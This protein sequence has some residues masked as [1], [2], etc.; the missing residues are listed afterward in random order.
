MTQP[1][2]DSP[3]ARSNEPSV[4][5]CAPAPLAIQIL[6]DGQ[7]RPRVE[8][9][10]PGRI[11]SDLKVTWFSSS[12]YLY[13]NFGHIQFEWSFEALG[14]SF[15]KAGEHP[16]SKNRHRVIVSDTCPAGGFDELTRPDVIALFACEGWTVELAV[17]SPPQLSE[18][19]S[20]GFAK[21]DDSKGEPSRFLA[22]L[23]SEGPAYLPMVP[24]S[25]T[26]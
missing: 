21:A 16:F 17:T 19:R 20:I 7:L 14:G 23:L 26:T 13:S 18:L 15:W 3:S 8:T 4:F 11:P 2:S 6:T 25:S 24:E 10:A 22:W 9:G 1:S 5:H 12:Q